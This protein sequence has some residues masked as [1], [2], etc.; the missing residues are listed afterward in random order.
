MCHVQYVNINF[1]Q[2][3]EAESAR[4]IKLLSIKKRVGSQSPKWVVRN[5]ILLCHKVTHLHNVRPWLSFVL[6]VVDQS[7]RTAPSD[8]SQQWGLTERRG[9][10]TDQSQ[11]RGLTERR[12]LETDQSQQRGLT[13]RRGLETDQSQQWG[14]TERR[15]LETDQSQQRGLTERR[16]L[17]TDQSQQRGLTERR[18]LE[19]DSSHKSF[20]NHLEMKKN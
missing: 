17:E 10:E 12:G 8:Q 4:Y 18:G 14:L 9:L 7:Q 16:G 15:G 13:E 6:Y 20:T 3:C 5:L 2:S 1:L 19:T 11:Q